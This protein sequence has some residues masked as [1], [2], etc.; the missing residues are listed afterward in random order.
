[1]QDKNIDGTDLIQPYQF[2]Q[3]IAQIDKLPHQPFVPFP[4]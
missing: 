4:W 1:M 2:L 3:I